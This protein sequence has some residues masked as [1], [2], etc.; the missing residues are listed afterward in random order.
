VCNCVL[1]L[2]KYR[3]PLPCATIKL[4]V[5][6][7]KNLPNTATNICNA[8]LWWNTGELPCCA[9]RLIQCMLYVSPGVYV[10][11]FTVVFISILMSEIW[12]WAPLLPVYIIGY[13]YQ[14]LIIGYQNN[15]LIWILVQHKT[16]NACK[17]TCFLCNY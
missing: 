3:S 12:W 8:K 9:H 6:C 5:G 2:K 16:L 4:I 13:Q 11:N 7:I 1:L 15:Q 17:I 10:H 14:P